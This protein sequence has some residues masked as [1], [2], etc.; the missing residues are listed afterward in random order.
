MRE[1]GW[2]AKEVMPCFVPKSRAGWNVERKAE[3][4][5]GR[6]RERETH[7]PKAVVKAVQAVVVCNS[8]KDRLVLGPAERS[9][10]PNFSI[11]H[12][13]KGLLCT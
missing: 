3:Y 2:Q 13:E 9:L 7:L 5:K 4:L 1:Q 6:G 8:V 10:P 11:S 12:E